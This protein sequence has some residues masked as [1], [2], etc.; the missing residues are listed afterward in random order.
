MGTQ[1]KWREFKT[2][3]SAN[4]DLFI[5][6]TET[7]NHRQHS[8]IIDDSMDGINA[9]FWPAIGQAHGVIPLRK[10]VAEIPQINNVIVHH[11]ADSKTAF[12]TS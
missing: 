3:A 11:D 8:V 7:L 9:L 2:S 5:D 12:L 4:H 10:Y 6:L 1:L